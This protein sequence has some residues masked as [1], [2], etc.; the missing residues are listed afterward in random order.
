M[1]G[2]LLLSPGIGFESIEYTVDEGGTLEVVVVKSAPFDSVIEFE[3]AGGN[4]SAVR[5]F[6]DGAS[7]PESI[8]IFFQIPDDVIA[9]EPPETI[10]FTLTVLDPNPQIS[11]DPDTTTVTILDNDG[12]FGVWLCCDSYDDE[13]HWALCVVLF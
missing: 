4:F 13:G 5:A 8:S 3:V 6:P 2:I 10:S 1:R 12:E 7:S 9:L 11:V